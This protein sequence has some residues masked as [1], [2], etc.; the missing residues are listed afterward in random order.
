MITGIYHQMI[1]VKKN[2][3]V[4]GLMMMMTCP[5]EVEAALNDVHV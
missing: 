1:I 4:G 3:A 2:S 5:L